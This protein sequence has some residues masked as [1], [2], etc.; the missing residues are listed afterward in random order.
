VAVAPDGRTLYASSLGPGTV[1][2]ID[3]HNSRVSATVSVG[4]PGTD[5]FNLA[6]TPSAVYVTEQGVPSLTVIDP[7]TQKVVANI[8]VGNDA[9]GVAVSR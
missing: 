4:T 5:P 9:Y 2:V 6:V 7:T 8:T 1:S 3:T